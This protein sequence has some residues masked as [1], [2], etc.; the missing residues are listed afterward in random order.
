M[1]ELLNFP[2]VNLAK[3]LSINMVVSQFIELNVHVYQVFIDA[4]NLDL[5]SLSNQF[6]QSRKTNIKLQFTFVASS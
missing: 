3:L 5:S 4:V 1:I 6:L 2:V